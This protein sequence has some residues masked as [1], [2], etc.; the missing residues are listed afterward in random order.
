MPSIYCILNDITLETCI[1]V[2]VVFE[3]RA[4]LDHLFSNPGQS[5]WVLDG[6]DEF[7]WKISAVARQRDQTSLDPQSSLPI[8]ELVSGLLSRRILPECTL[9]VT[10]RPRDVVDLEGAA[11]SVGELLGLDR[12]GVTE[13]VENYFQVKGE[14]LFPHSLFDFNLLIFTETIQINWH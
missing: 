5:C 8:A 6:Y 7:H 3:Q 10:C 4:V 11:D 9:V 14:Q 13:F 12:R 2:P 1:V